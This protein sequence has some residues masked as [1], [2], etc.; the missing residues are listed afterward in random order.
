MRWELL[1]HITDEN[2]LTISGRRLITAKE[3]C[4]VV[5][6]SLKRAGSRGVETEALFFGEKDQ[7]QHETKKSRHYHLAFLRTMSADERDHIREGFE[8]FGPKIRY[9]D[10]NIIVAKWGIQHSLNY[11]LRHAVP[12]LKRF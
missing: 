9:S 11:L 1:S 10:K 2:C 3:V 6:L 8:F 7:A 12:F 4:G 5:R